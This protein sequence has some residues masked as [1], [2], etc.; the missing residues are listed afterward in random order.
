MRYTLKQIKS[1]LAEVGYKLK[2]RGDFNLSFIGVRSRTEKPKS[3]NDLFCV[4]FKIGGQEQFWQ[5]ECTTDPMCFYKNERH[6]LRGFEVL[7]PGV[8]KNLWKLD[9]HRG[10]YPALVQQNQADVFVWEKGNSE[11]E[12]ENVE[13]K[14]VSSGVNC[15]RAEGDELGAFSIGCQVIKNANEYSMLI[16]LCRRADITESIQFDYVLLEQSTIEKVNQ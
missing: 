13:R 4:I 2:S 5:F 6:Q 3:F 16:S 9:R 12:I 8:Y 14:S 1:A 10:L 7:I 11:L 15:C